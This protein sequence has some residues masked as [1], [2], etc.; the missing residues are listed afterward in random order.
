MKYKYK[1]FIFT[2]FIPYNT[3]ANISSLLIGRR[4]YV[5]FRWNQATSYCQG[6]NLSETVKTYKLQSSLHHII[7]LLYY[8]L[9]AKKYSKSRAKP[10]PSKQA[11]VA[12]LGLNSDITLFCSYLT[13]MIQIHKNT[14]PD[15]RSQPIYRFL[16]KYQIFLS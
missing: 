7:A 6:H 1:L 8:F 5:L 3:M 10:S 16:V 9:S 2:I 13:I 14:C 15:Q 12:F 11:T 4:T